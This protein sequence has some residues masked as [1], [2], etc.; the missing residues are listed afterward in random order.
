M[1]ALEPGSDKMKCAAPGLLKTADV[2]RTAQHPGGKQSPL[3]KAKTTVGQPGR[4]QRT[5]QSS[6]ASRLRAAWS[7]PRAG[8]KTR[9]GRIWSSRCFS[10]A[11]LHS[12]AGRTAH[13]FSWASTLPMK[14]K[15]TYVIKFEM[16]KHIWQGAVLDDVQFKLHRH[17]L[18]PD[19]PVLA[20]VEGLTPN[21]EQLE[22]CRHLWRST[23]RWISGW[24]APA[25]LYSHT[26]VRYWRL[27]LRQSRLQK[28]AILRF[29]SNKPESL[30]ISIARTRGTTTNQSRR[31]PKSACPLR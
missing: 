18:H 12:S 4:S 17:R 27:S 11:L 29:A 7:R 6:K 22:M 19:S 5:A 3:L 8:T 31:W 28:A 15:M 24:R 30:P 25:L 21:A 20:Q 23:R 10:T 26:R 16:A 1:S 14:L 2:P 13:S 9:S